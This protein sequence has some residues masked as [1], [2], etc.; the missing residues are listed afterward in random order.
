M[1]NTTPYLIVYPNG[2][3]R[4]ISRTELATLDGLKQ[5]GPREYAATYTYAETLIEQTNGPNYLELALVFDYPPDREYEREQT[6]KGM[7]ARLEAMG[8]E[9]EAVA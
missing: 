2:I 8:W 6:P 3:K 9:S 5:T 1:A 4:H 7:I